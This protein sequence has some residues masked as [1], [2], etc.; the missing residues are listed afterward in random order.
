MTLSHCDK[1]V[2]DKDNTDD[3]TLVRVKTHSF[4]T[5]GVSV[6]HSAAQWIVSARVK[7]VFRTGSSSWKDK[8]CV[9]SFSEIH[10]NQ[11]DSRHFPHEAGESGINHHK[12]EK[13]GHADVLLLD[14]TYSEVYSAELLVIPTLFINLDGVRQLKFDSCSSSWLIKH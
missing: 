8:R 11:E 1:H 4:H 2:A 10:Q 9:V 6:S 12:Y 3:V 7:S 13:Q 14:V 5:H